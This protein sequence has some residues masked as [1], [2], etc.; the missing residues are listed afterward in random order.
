M[1]LTAFKAQG[2]KSFPD[3]V[4]FKVG[5][6]LIGVV[7][8][9]GCGKSN[10]VDAVRWVLGESRLSALRGRALPDVLFNGSQARPPAD[11]CGVDLTFANDGSRDLGAWS[12]YSEIAANWGGTDNRFF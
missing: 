9:N 5:E 6:P 11:W 3:A 1:R 12:S 7:G 4:S 8:P 2:F 10:V